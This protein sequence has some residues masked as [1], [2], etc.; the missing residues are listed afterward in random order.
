MHTSGASPHVTGVLGVMYILNECLTFEEAESILKIGST[1]IDHIQ[2]NQFAAGNYGSGSLNAYKSVKL[3][4]VLISPNEVVYIEDQI[5]QDNS[6]LVLTSKSSIELQENTFFAPNS[7]GEINL[8]IED[9]GLIMDTNCIT[10]STN[11]MTKSKNNDDDLLR[12]PI[13]KVFSSL[14]E[15]QLT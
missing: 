4:K 11:S 9:E 14:F 6:I 3:T 10:L 5:F 12:E 1:N 7:N 13:I 8:I 2:A 15:D